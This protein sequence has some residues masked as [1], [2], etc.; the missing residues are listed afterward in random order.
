MVN[1]TAT[2]VGDQIVITM[3]LAAIAATIQSNAKY[4]AADIA[5][6][7]DIDALAARSSTAFTTATRSRP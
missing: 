4:F 1:Y 5:E 7:V 3:P 6:V 2:R